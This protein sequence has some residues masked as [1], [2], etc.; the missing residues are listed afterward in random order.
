MRQIGRNI[1]ISSSFYDYDIESENIR[2]LIENRVS[3][4]IL[5]GVG[6]QTYPKLQ[7]YIGKVPMVFLGDN[8]PEGLVSQITVNN[9]EGTCIATRYLISLGYRNL[10]FLGGRESS[11]THQHRHKG[12]L[13]TTSKA[14][15]V[16]HEIF[17][18]LSGSRIEDGYRTGLAYF[19]QCSEQKRQMATGILCIS[20]HFALG[21]MQAAAEC[22]VD[23]P[24]QVSLIGFDD[25][26][27]AALPRIQLTTVSQP[28]EEICSV[29]VETLEEL[30]RTNNY[31]ETG[32]RVIQ[33]VLVR[34]DSC[35]PPGR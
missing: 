20:D 11:I 24:R 25:V 15:D 2:A 10:A 33:P 27:F 8:I 30:I 5:S 19:D 18:C 32:R 35:A 7:D 16:K 6:D 9:Y 31:T 12:F 26:S 29:A 13:D 3:G 14:A 34:R 28:K 22:G 17:T 4:I 23:I 1:F 21:F